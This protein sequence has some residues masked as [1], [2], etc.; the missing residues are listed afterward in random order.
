[1]VTYCS[2]KMEN[3]FNSSYKLIATIFLRKPVAFLFPRRGHTCVAIRE[4]YLH[5][6]QTDNQPVWCLKQ[7]SRN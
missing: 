4:N 5:M 2:E 7:A 3:Q 6:D 1:M